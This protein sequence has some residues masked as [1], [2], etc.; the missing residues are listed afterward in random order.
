MSKFKYQIPHQTQMIEIQMLPACP[1]HEDL[2]FDL[3][4]Q[5]VDCHLPACRQAGIL[6]FT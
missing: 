6:I 3:I 5:L 2:V 4:R 1:N